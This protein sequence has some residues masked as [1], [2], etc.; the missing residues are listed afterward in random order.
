MGG[1][2]KGLA[3]GILGSAGI[4]AALIAAREAGGGKGGSGGASRAAGDAAA[5]KVRDLERRLG[6]AEA[7]LGSERERHRAQAEALASERD[8]ARREAEMKGAMLVHVEDPSRKLAE[9]RRR[10]QPALEWLQKLSPETFGDLT[11]DELLAMRL[12]DLTRMGVTDEDLAHLKGLPSLQEL[13][14]NGT[15]V[16]DAGL[17]H[18]KDVKGLK[19]LDLWGAPVTGEGLRHL[20][21]TVEKLSLLAT[22]TVTE[23]GLQSLR[24]MTGLRSLAL[25]HTA[26]SDR[27]ASVLE[28]MESLRSLSLHGTRSGDGVI[29]ALRGLKSLESLDLAGTQISDKGLEMLRGVPLRFARIWQC[30]NLTDEGISRFIAEHPECHLP[31]VRELPGGKT[32]P[33]YPFQ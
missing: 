17:A 1:F 19:A 22:G 4:A 21:P 28:G 8:A 24:G 16:T 12:L 27:T 10:V 15:Q 7:L 23:E 2:G 13:K 14:L 11:A 33:F 25:G 3:L 9:E 6:E 20:P 32:Y 26:M 5:G 31:S 18:L 29:A 30:P